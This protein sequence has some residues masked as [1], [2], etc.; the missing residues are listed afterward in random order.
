M[1]L[2]ATRITHSCRQ[3]LCLGLTIWRL[4]PVSLTHSCFLYLYICLYL[5]LG[6]YH[7]LGPYGD[8]NR[9]DTAAQ[10]V[11]NLT[12]ADIAQGSFEHSISVVRTSY[13][14]VAAVRVA[15]PNELALIWFSQYQPYSSSYSP[16]YVGSDT[17][18]SPLMRSEHCVAS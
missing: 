12:M 6:L 13:S 17:I 7:S 2:S 3:Y 5:C 10:P 16:V 8:P 15:E 14:L 18:P 11:D 1:P 9:Y 4:Q